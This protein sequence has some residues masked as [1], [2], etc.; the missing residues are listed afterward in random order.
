[1]T[2]QERSS[3]GRTLAANSSELLNET[4]CNPGST[5]RKVDAV[6]VLVFASQPED[7][8]VSGRSIDYEQDVKRILQLLGCSGHASFF[9][10]HRYFEPAIHASLVWVL[11]TYVSRIVH[12]VIVAP[13]NPIDIVLAGL[14]TDAD[15]L[16]Q[17]LAILPAAE[18]GIR[19]T[20]LREIETK[21]KQ[22][23]TLLDR[24][25]DT[26]GP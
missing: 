3:F 25:A 4:S 5:G 1:V 18:R 17:L 20:V 24:T 13:E 16:R 12:Y 6:V 11:L 21:I 19:E 8:G 10:G 9:K 22:L 26:H 7:C 15:L 2:H 23:E 14:R